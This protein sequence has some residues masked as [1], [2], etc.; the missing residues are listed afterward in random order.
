MITSTSIFI[1]TS[2]VGFHCWPQAPEDTEFLRTLHRHVF[3][4]RVEVGVSDSRQVEF[5]QLKSDVETLIV[6]YVLPHL[7]K[8]IDSSCE[9]LAQYLLV[10]VYN[11]G[12][13]AV[14]SVTISED[15]ENGATVRVEN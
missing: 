12:Y 2:F 5:F 10:R 7:R 14:R 8:N 1:T 13:A 9:Q 3:H 4:V 6:D 15:G 11:A